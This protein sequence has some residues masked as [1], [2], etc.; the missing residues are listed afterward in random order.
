MSS[1]PDCPAPISSREQVT[2]FLEFRGGFLVEGRE[3]VEPSNDANGMLCPFVSHIA[4]LLSNGN[5]SKIN[6]M[7]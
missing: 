1:T 5:D 3:G 7:A 6:A 4:G 2:L